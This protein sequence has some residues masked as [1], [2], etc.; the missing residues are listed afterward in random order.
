[1]LLQAGRDDQ[2]EQGAALTKINV[3]QPN[4]PGLCSYP[5]NL[6]CKAMAIIKGPPLCSYP[7]SMLQGNGL[8]Q[9]GFPHPLKTLQCGW[10]GLPI[11]LSFPDG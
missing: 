9:R 8:D 1:M 5:C 7:C 6:G 2:V 4:C 11:V 10:G 3:V